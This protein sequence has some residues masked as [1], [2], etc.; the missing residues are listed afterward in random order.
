MKLHNHAVPTRRLTSFWGR[1]KSSGPNHSHQKL[2]SATSEQGWSGSHSD[3][4]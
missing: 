3:L 1:E 4:I 2:S